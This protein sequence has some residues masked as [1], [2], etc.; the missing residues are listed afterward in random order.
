LGEEVLERIVDLRQNEP[1]ASHP[2]PENDKQRAMA[3]MWQADR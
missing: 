2:S 1:T 3:K